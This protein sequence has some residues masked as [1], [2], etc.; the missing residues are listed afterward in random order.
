MLLIYLESL[1]DSQQ[2]QL[3]AWHQNVNYWPRSY[4]N[5]DR[6]CPDI[7]T[8]WWMLFSHSGLADL[9]IMR[10]PEHTRICRTLFD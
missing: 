9:W 1:S 5:G 6:A 8:D 7:V 4:P 10:Y 2:L 3:V